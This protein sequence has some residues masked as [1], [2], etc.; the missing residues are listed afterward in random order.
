MLT[1]PSHMTMHRIKLTT[2]KTLVF[3]FVFDKFVAGRFLSIN[4]IETQRREVRRHCEKATRSTVK[5]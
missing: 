5:P 4:F 2:Q 3:D 1:S